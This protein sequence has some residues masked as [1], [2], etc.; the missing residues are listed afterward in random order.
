M[1]YL[2]TRYDNYG[3]SSNHS[4][5]VVDIIHASKLYYWTDSI[6]ILQPVQP[7]VIRNILNLV[8]TM[9]HWFKR[10]FGHNRVWGILDALLGRGSRYKVLW[11][12]AP[13]LGPKLDVQG[14]TKSFKHCWS[15][16]E[17][18][19]GGGVQGNSSPKS[20]YTRKR[21]KTL[22]LSPKDMPKYWT[23]RP[24]GWTKYSQEWFPGLLNSA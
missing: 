3:A 8:R 4:L 19:R 9:E 10:V 7:T 16:L 1:L 11:A 22:G 20:K 21:G 13:V 2:L 24:Q 6:R 18:S 23:I 17:K 15:S 12:R 5:F 14:P